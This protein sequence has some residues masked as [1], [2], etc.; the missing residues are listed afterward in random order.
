MTQ[1]IPVTR[2]KRN[3]DVIT[4]DSS[5]V[6]KIDKVRENEYIVHTA[7][8]KYY[9]NTSFDAVEE[10][11]YEDG[12]R[13][14]DSN[15]IVNM[16]RVS[17]Y[18]P[19]RG[20]IYLTDSEGG[21]LLDKTASAARIHR[22]HIENLLK[23]LRTSSDSRTDGMYS[24]SEPLNELVD[25]LAAAGEHP[26]FMKSYSAMRISEERKRV[27]EKINYLAFH[28]PLTGLPN[29]L[30]FKER[31]SSC[32]ADARRTGKRPAVMFFDLDRFK[33]INDTLGHH[34]GDEMLRFLSIQMRSMVGQEELIARF[35]G[36][37]FIV[38][39]PHVENPA[40]VAEYARRLSDLISQPFLFDDKELFVTVSIGAAFFPQDGEDAETLIK[41]ADTAMYR[42]KE[43]GGD[44]F[45]FYHP[46]M[47]FR[48]LERL[49]LETDLRKALHKKQIIIHYQPLVN[50][51]S[52]AIFG[53][54]A[55]VR[56]HHSELG[57]V[58]PG[59][60]IPIA[61]ETGLI[62]PIGNWVLREACRQNKEWQ[63]K[64][65][66]LC[67]AVNISMQ[68]FQHP[69]FV[70]SIRD[71]LADNDLN[72]QALC[73]EIT[74]TVAMKNVGFVME[75]IDELKKI[76]VHISIDD[77]GT[78]YSSLNYLKRFRVHTLK[79]DRSFIRDVTTDEDNAAIV[80]ALI[81]MSQQMKMRSLAE[82]VETEEQLNFLR[83]RGCNEVQGY[84]YSK[85]L[86]PNE[87]EALIRKSNLN[88]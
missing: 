59:D 32:F 41:H 80:T 60:F 28:D 4:I 50:L 79:I 19:D 16:N 83:E 37:E 81:A 43:K 38:L 9:L 77:F 10:W 64:G 36:D 42:A 74:E 2:D 14:L 70:Q 66:N 6:V 73:L 71:A 56:W 24:S 49:Q 85:P 35:S 78:G 62:I 75:T 69:D 47:N 27:E 65:F 53:M 54:E 68:Q 67:V 5:Q 57:L 40:H 76:G 17:G 44:T 87:F 63:T 84:I 25:Q 51:E 26:M 23:I 45:E 55:L 58:S 88:A 39:L 11:L 13:M 29:R 15:N 46:E 21:G 48:S 20:T 86:P 52:G 18:D 82:G 1:R 33:V 3:G 22:Q 7:F 34:V 31:L 30:L 61:E 8:D 72:P 12:F